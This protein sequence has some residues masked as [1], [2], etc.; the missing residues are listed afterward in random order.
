M[1]AGD[2]RRVDFGEPIGSEPGLVRPALLVTSDTVLERNPRTV[3]VVPITSNVLRALPTDVLLDQ[4]G[5]PN[6]SAAQVHLCTVISTTR[7]ITNNTE[8]NVGP[9]ALA[10]I[11]SVLADLLDIP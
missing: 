6:Q 1:R 11:R 7:I 5:L 10:Q 9:T 4:T 3:H 8:G 2:I